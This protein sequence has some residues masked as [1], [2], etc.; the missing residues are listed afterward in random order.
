MEDLNTTRHSCISLSHAHIF[1]LIHT[2][3]PYVTHSHTHTFTKPIFTQQKEREAERHTHTFRR[4]YHTHT[5]TRLILN[6][7]WNELNMCEYGSLSSIFLSTSCSLFISFVKLCL[8]S[9]NVNTIFE[10]KSTVLILFRLNLGQ[11]LNKKNFYKS[12]VLWY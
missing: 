5:G 11:K 10:A 6:A 7:S 12:M 8:S 9:F 4:R 3:T 1:T 2:H